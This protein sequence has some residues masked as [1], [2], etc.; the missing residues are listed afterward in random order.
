MVYRFNIPHRMSDKFEFMDEDPKRGMYW[1]L[2]IGAH[3]AKD[4]PVPTIVRQK[5]TAAVPDLFWLPGVCAC[6][7]RAKAIFEEFESGVHQFFPLTALR[8][9][10][11]PFEEKYYIINIGQKFDCLMFNKGQRHVNLRSDVTAVPYLKYTG[12]WFCSR[13]KVGN[14]HFWRAA[15]YHET[16]GYVS[17]LLYKRLKK[18]KIRRFESYHYEEVDEVWNAEEQ[19]PE[20]LDWYERAWADLRSGKMTGEAGN[21]DRSCESSIEWLR[22]HR[23]HFFPEFE[24]YLKAK[25]EKGLR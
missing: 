17:E 21:L 24:N 22:E 9:S 5:D 18:E 19:I 7:E 10:G 12:D 3:I 6:N 11:T 15:F 8:K 4:F 25:L 20:I 14:R 16:D 23:P 13:Q 1:S 2:G